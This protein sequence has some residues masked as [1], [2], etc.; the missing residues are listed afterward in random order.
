MRLAVMS[1]IHGN[2]EAFTRCLLDIEQSGVD[3]I[4]NLGDAIGYGPQ[5]EE[6]LGIL[7]E[8]GIPNILGNHELA[9]VDKDARGDLSPLAV[10]SLEQTLKYLSAASLLYIKNLPSVREMEGALLVHGCPPDSQTIYM[11]HMSL[12][13]IRE[14]F[15]A[16]Q[17][18]IAF[19][20]HSHRL[21]LISYDE[22]KLEVTSLRHEIIQLR[23]GYRH[24]VNVGSAGQPRDGDPNAKYVIWDSCRNTLEI[25]RIAYDVARTAFLIK[26]RGFLQRDAERL[27]SGICSE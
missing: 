20:G 15:A 26:K 14:I 16:T 9:V 5:P 6:V 4:V 10:R 2:F 22:K 8:R 3:Q 11:H 13:E 7:E 21:M 23:P 17:F 27:F 12:P 24:I 1:D 19:V 25:R 18:D